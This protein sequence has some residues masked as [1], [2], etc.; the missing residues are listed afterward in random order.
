MRKKNSNEILIG[1]LSDDTILKAT[2]GDKD[3]IAAVMEAYEPYIIDQST[4]DKGTP[5]EHVDA[6][7]AQTLRLTLL[8]KIPEFK[9]AEK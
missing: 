3:A 6:D 5:Q 8:E 1:K 2:Q 7:L 4:V 9:F